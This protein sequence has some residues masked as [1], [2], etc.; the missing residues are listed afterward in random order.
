MVLGTPAYM[1]PEQA[2]GLEVDTRTD[3]WAFGC[4]L[5]E[6]LTGRRPFEGITPADTLA[7]VLTHD[8]DMTIVSPDTPA[9]A[10]SLLRACLEKDPERRPPDM[11]AARLAIDDALSRLNQPVEST[12]TTER[13]ALPVPC[14]WIGMSPGRAHRA[15]VWAAAVAAV[16]L[17]LAA[18]GLW[19]SRA[20]WLEWCRFR[21]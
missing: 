12:Q 14:L 21:R 7:A 6:L 11:A 15:R 16:A 8:P 3:I 18:I 2:R 13:A 10:R 4:L 1:S 20:T 5:Y 9:A 17:C 19:R